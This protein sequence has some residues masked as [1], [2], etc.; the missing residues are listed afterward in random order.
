MCSLCARR[1]DT[2]GRTL[3]RDHVVRGPDTEFCKEHAAICSKCGEA[4]GEDRSR[5]CALCGMIVCP[6]CSAVC[7]DCQSAIC[8]THALAK[9][10]ECLVCGRQIPKA[11]QLQMF[12]R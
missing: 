6:K 7:P 2:C 1:C 11:E 10:P 12:E 3:C 9:T 8:T 5:S 4:H